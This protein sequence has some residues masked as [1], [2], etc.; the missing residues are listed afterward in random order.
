MSDSFEARGFA[1]ISGVLAESECQSWPLAWANR[2]SAVGVGLADDQSV[3][4]QPLEL[5]NVPLTEELLDQLCFANSSSA[6]DHD[7]RGLVQSGHRLELSP[8]AVAP[9]E[10]RF[11]ADGRYFIE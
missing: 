6:V 3:G 10:I 9:C 11:F 1:V 4:L 7:D 8:I 2:P 5:Q